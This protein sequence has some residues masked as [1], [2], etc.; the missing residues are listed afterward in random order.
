MWLIRGETA[1]PAGVFEAGSS[2]TAVLQGDMQPGDL[3]AVTIEPAG[4]SPTGQP[5]TDPL[6]AIAT[7]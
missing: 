4:G 2:T 6:F 3:V 5:T 7:G 1:Q